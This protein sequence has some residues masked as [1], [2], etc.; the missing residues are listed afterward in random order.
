MLTLLQ[1][2]CV[3]FGQ[4]KRRM[5]EERGNDSPSQLAALPPT[6][7]LPEEASLGTAV[8]FTGLLCCRPPHHRRRNTDG[9]LRM[10]SI[11]VAIRLGA[12]YSNYMWRQRR[13][14]FLILHTGAAWFQE[15]SS[16]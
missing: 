15:P 6:E 12:Q 16:S 10:R 4:N 13:V 7:K 2:K 14:C 11:H 5:R 3:R 8:K 9:A 1:A